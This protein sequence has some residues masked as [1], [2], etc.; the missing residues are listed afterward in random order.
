MTPFKN[1]TCWLDFEISK[2]KW[3]FVSRILHVLKHPVCLICCLP[4][5]LRCFIVVL[6]GGWDRLRCRSL[7]V[8]CY[9]SDHLCGNC[10]RQLTDWLCTKKI[11]HTPLLVIK[12]L[13]NMLINIPTISNFFFLWST[14]CCVGYYIAFYRVF[15][16]SFLISIFTHSMKLNY[17]IALF[18]VVYPCLSSSSVFLLSR[19]L[20][21]IFS[22]YLSPSL[23]LVVT[24][25]SSLSFLIMPRIF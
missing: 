8:C 9:S 18:P 6:G 21:R 13:A 20:S 7:I 15:N 22:P 14:P 3:V 24:T 19:Q 1:L 2:H 10:L 5:F 4:P 23:F 12:C 17:W 11:W 16:K 25:C